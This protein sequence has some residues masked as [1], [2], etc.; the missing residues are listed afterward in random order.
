[1]SRAVKSRACTE[2]GTMSADKTRILVVEDEVMIA[3]LLEDMLTDLGHEVVGPATRIE[4]GLALAERERLD[5]AVLDINLNGVRS[6]PIADLL[7]RR[8]IPFVVATGYGSDGM[9]DPGDAR[10]ILKKPFTP[11]DLDSAINQ[12]ITTARG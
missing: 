2:R 10:H 4:D 3:M 7:S 6:T 11:E 9:D 5:V 8:G 12:V 1:M